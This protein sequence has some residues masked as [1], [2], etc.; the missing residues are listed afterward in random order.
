MLRKKVRASQSCYKIRQNVDRFSI[1]ARVRFL[2]WGRQK[3]GRLN[4]D[5]RWISDATSKCSNFFAIGPILKFFDFS[6][7]SDVLVFIFSHCSSDSD[8]VSDYR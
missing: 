1:E 3:L 8:Y 7:S 2:P 6:E 5:F 4:L